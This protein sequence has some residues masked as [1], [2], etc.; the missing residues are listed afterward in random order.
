MS[1]NLTDNPFPLIGY[2]KPEYF[3]D[4]EKE[5]AHMT[6]CIDNKRNI[7]LFANRRLGKTG[8]IQHTLHKLSKRRNHS[9]IYFDVLGTGTL[10]E[11][12]KTFG[13]AVI[14]KLDSKALKLL[15]TA[16][17]ILKALR[18]KITYDALTGEPE[19][20]IDVKTDKEAIH[21]LEEIFNYLK[22]RS[23]TQ[24]IIIAIDEFQQVLEYPEKNTEAL[25]R[26]K[27]QMLPAVSFIFSGSSK[28]LLM[29]MF[30]DTRRPFYQST[31]LLE[32][33]KINPAVY[34]VFIKEHFKKGKKKISDDDI[35]H[36]LE[37]TRNV[38]F[39]VQS[40]CNRLYY[41]HHKNLTR[42]II[43]STLYDLLME[44]E[45]GFF[46]LRSL[47]TTQQWNMLIAIAREDGVKEPSGFDFM[48][49]HK[50]GA[51]SSVR[52]ALKSLLEKELVVMEDAKFQ[53]YDVFFSRWLQRL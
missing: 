11:F 51:G 46:N 31:D 6:K 27:I 33:Q 32:L 3:C 44:R 17:G 52:A 53:V 18:P 29:D 9:V 24:K 35:A 43:N 10:R 23:K 50:V 1:E 42:E 4:R 39:F 48:H 12:V 30:T 22:E 15:N 25:L 26:S 20:S 13:G 34:S 28:H 21:T 38:T 45:A 5:L 36:I 7:T 49:K 8:L 19:V 47:L 2:E 41:L 14:G 40:V 37:W 16:T